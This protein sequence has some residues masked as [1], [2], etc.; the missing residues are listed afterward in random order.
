MS[1]YNI[2]PR[3]TETEM[4]KRRSDR[5]GWTLIAFCL[6]GPVGVAYGCYK[7]DEARGITVGESFAA[8]GL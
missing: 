5:I 1:R 6:L 7:A 8:W 2:K 3:R 4:R